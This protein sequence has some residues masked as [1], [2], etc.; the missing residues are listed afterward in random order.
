MKILIEKG[1]KF[2]E[3]GGWLILIGMVS[4]MT[5]GTVMRYIFRSPLLFQVD[6]VEL[7]LLLFCCLCFASVFLRGGHIR[8][9][10]VTDHLPKR[11]QD[12][13]WLFAELITIVFIVLLAI[14]FMPL[15]LHSLDINAASEVVEIP[16]A[17]FQFFT[18][19]GFGT[20]TLVLFVD[21][22][23]RCKKLLKSREA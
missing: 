7:A 14:V 12:W 20:F 21:F 22:C 17:P 9:T 1:A 8:V 5:I 11:V 16:L 4:V 23:E 19:I 2:L 18:I 13:L 6:L 10:L 3:Y 15:I